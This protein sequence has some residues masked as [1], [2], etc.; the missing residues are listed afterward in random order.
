MIGADTDPNSGDKNG[1]DSPAVFTK[2]AEL[3]A[4]VIARNAGRFIDRQQPQPQQQSQQTEVDSRTYTPW[5]I[6]DLLKS[7]KTPLDELADELDANGLRD[8][9]VPGLVVDEAIK[10][11]QSEHPS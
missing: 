2:S 9:E 7:I 10:K 3:Q 5:I 4:F 1:D 8:G 11:W 6:V